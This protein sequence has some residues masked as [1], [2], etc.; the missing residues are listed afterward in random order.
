MVMA[1]MH[2]RGIVVFVVVTTICKKGGQS[3]D[4]VA[5]SALSR[6]EQSFDDRVDLQGNRDEV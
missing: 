1:G 4:N 5:R 6:A 3:R 2:A